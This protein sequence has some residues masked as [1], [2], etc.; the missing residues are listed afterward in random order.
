[1]IYLYIKTHRKTGLKYFG[2]TIRDDYEFYTGSGKYWLRH[3]KKHGSDVETTLLGSY[4]SVDIAKDR[5]L[6]FSKENDIVKS[7]DWA[8]L[9]EENA[10][11][12]APVGHKPYW[13]PTEEERAQQA[14]KVKV[15]WQDP[16]YKQTVLAT[17]QATFDKKF[18]AMSIDQQKKYLKDKEQH[19]RWKAGEP[20]PKDSYI[21][22]KPEDFRR[23]VSE[24]LKGKVKSEEHKKKISESRKSNP[25][26]YTEEER[27]SKSKKMT[28]RRWIN[29][30]KVSKMCKGDLLA[31]LL[32][33]GWQ[34]GR[35]NLPA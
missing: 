14:N 27:K 22:K 34:I 28:G 1:M 20:I 17:R 24:A 35:L 4:D 8:N 19:R 6:A 16:M 29:D 13:N 30:G 11:D 18:L 12:G 15:R 23:K 7:P 33:E 2:K 25:R 26:V 5:A 10:C 31:T 3:L 9:Q 21:Y 32:E